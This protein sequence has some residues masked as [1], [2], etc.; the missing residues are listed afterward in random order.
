MIT[1]QY[2]Q[3]YDASPS[4]AWTNASQITSGSIIQV[5]WE[6]YNSTTQKYLPFNLTRIVN[7]G[8]DDIWFNPQQ[9]ATRKVL[10]PKGTIITFDRAYIPAISSFSITHAGTTTISANKIILTNSREAQ[11]TDSIVA[12]L[13]ERLF[14]KKRKD[15]I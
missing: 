9:D 6:N 14:S 7:N 8:E 2:D 3:I 1:K 11:S 5:A 13:H 4:F 10:V 12:R 15:V